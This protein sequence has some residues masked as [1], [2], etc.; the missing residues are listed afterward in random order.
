M[1]F[2]LPYLLSIVLAVP[3]L[4]LIMG[5][6]SKKEQFPVEGRVRLRSAY[7]AVDQP[8]NEE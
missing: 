2:S 8:T 1:D 4:I 3:T 7:V 5:F 6:F